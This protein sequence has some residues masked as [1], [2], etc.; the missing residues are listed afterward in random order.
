MGRKK[1]R[2]GLRLYEHFRLKHPDQSSNPSQFSHYTIQC[3]YLAA[4]ICHRSAGGQPAILRNRCSGIK[5]QLRY[6]SRLGKIARNSEW[7]QQPQKESLIEWWQRTEENC[8]E[9]KSELSNSIRGF[10]R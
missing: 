7:I 8:H 1:R 9:E 6:L 5:I 4:C 3:G 10:V 2:R